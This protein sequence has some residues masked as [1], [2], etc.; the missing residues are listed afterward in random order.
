[1][2]E[3]KDQSGGLHKIG[4]IVEVIE[5][6]DIVE[7]VDI[8]IYAK[9]NRKPPRA[10]KYKFRIDREHFT[11]EHRKITGAKLF[12]L[13]NKSP[14]EYRMHQKLHGGQMKEVKVD[15]TID[16]GEP[17][18]ERFA[19]MKLSE[20]DGEQASS[21]EAPV[22]TAPRREFRLPSD[23]EGYLNSLGLRWEAIQC[24]NGRWVLLH[25]H[26]LPAGYVQ[27]SA[28]VAIRIEGGYPPGALDMASFR[29]AL[30]RAD[31]KALIK[32][33]AVTIEEN[34]YQQWSR[35]YTWQEDLDSLASHHLHVK[36]WLE[37]E[38]NR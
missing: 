8:E 5:E 10:R 34:E 30:A 31:G 25:N 38:P 11:T 32:V 4:E 16:L 6:G 28:T 7:I 3:E 23:D 18:I 13:A 20:G 12:E 15:E 24:P 22:A 1:M 27:Q 37:A 21:T 26:P 35:H 19:T 14:A 36:N 2:T 33:S 17:G 9:D 29:P